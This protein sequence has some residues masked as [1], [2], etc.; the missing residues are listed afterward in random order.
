VWKINTIQ[1]LKCSVL[2]CVF[3]CKGKGKVHPRTGHEGLEGSRDIPY[4]YFNLSAKWGWVVIATPRPLY[5]RERLGTHC[6]GDWVGTRS[7]L[8]RCGKSCPYWI[9]SPDR[10]AHS[11]SLHQLRYP[12]PLYCILPV[13]ILCCRI[14]N[15]LSSLMFMC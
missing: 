6:I 15:F 10:P 4:S 1:A 7:A 8:D 12:G 2:L 13:G 3:H 14:T 9:R 5:P 11:E